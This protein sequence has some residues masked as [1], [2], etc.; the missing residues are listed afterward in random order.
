MSI[1]NNFDDLVNM[2]GESSG[3]LHILE[4]FEAGIQSVMPEKVMKEF[5]SIKGSLFP[6]E[7]I[8]C[9]WGKASL[10]MLLAFKKNYEGEISEGL[11]IVP[12]IGKKRLGGSKIKVF[13]GA[14][15]LP[16]G[17]SIKSGVKILEFANELNKDDTLVCLISGGGSAMFEVPKDG[18]DLQNLREIYKL[19]SDTGADIHEVNS[20][21]RALSKNKGGGLAKYA[22]PARIIN[23]VIS[24]VPGNNLEDIASGPTVMDPLIIK[25]NDIIKKY[26]LEKKVDARI[27]RKVDTYRP[28]ERGYF[29]NVEYYIIGDNKKAV[30]AMLIKAREFGFNPIRYKEQIHGEARHAVKDFM[31][32]EGELIIGGGETTVNIKGKGKG[33]RN[34]EFVLSGLKKLKHG[35]LASVGTDGKDGNT[36]AAGALADEEVIENAN[37]KGFDV[38]TFLDNN[39]SYEFFKGCGGLIKTGRTG[40]NVADICLLLR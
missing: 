29:R 37:R 17:T 35:I 32:T 22:Y 26:G 20:V 38:D 19:L 21:R 25:P 16:D 23:I 1:F 28:I 11:I 15:P 24:D 4:M 33:G 6:P 9:G 7:V 2:N 40:T 34:Q 12:S 3:R 27:L 36:D 18:V 8:I 5:F 30:E 10:E 14:H 31:E 39:D 13:K